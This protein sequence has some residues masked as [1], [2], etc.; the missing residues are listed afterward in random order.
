MGHDLL[1]VLVG[2][3]ATVETIDTH[4]AT[5]DDNG[6]GRSSVRCGVPVLQDGVT[7]WYFPRQM[8]FYTVSW[9]LATW[10]AGHV[11][12]FDVVH[13]RGG[14]T[15]TSLWRVAAQLAS[16]RRASSSGE[17]AGA[18]SRVR[19]RPGSAGRG[20]VSK[21]VARRWLQQTGTNSCPVRW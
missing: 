14:V 2:D 11:S 10:L 19:A 9:P 8:R 15:W 17:P 20:M 12:E 5:T 1:A 3:N 13:V 6:P 18:V 7:Y 21:L 16:I 4:L